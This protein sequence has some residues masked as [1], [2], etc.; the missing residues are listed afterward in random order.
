MIRVVKK[1]GEV[2][3]KWDP[4]AGANRYTVLSKKPGEQAFRVLGVTADTEFTDLPDGDS[5]IYSVYGCY[6]DAN[7]AVVVVGETAPSVQVD[8]AE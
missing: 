6:A 2:T 3:L 4:A 5:V 1:T 8:F 7:G